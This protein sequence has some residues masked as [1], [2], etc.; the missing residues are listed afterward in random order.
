VADPSPNVGWRNRERKTLP[1]RGR[2]D[3]ILCLALIHHL[4]ISSNIPV[5]DFIDWLASLESDLIIEFVT[6]ED[7][8]A[9]K[10][11]R[12]KEDQYVDYDVTFFEQC[13]AEAFQVDRRERLA[14]GTRI[15]YF[16][17]CRKRCSEH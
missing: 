5:R 9:R 11:L 3:L 16:A 10:L 4:V 7:P 17:R 13:L 15:L 1:E 12:N 6:K 14:S 2:P 8:M